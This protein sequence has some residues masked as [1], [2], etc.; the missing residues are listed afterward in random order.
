[1]S[2]AIAGAALGAASARFAMHRREARDQPL[3]V[4]VGP[5]EGGGFSVSLHYTFR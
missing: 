3:D 2:D 5:A 4:A 1:M